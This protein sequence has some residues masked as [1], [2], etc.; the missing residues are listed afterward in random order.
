[1]ICCTVPN[2]EHNSISSHSAPSGPALTERASTLYAHQGASA[3]SLPILSRLKTIRQ[4]SGGE[5]ER[6]RTVDSV[7]DLQ[8]AVRVLVPQALEYE[9]HV[10]CECY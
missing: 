7:H 10:R 9:L 8:A 2:A 3:R 1:M 6:K 5:H 4:R